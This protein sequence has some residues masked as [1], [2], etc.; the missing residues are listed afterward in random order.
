MYWICQI[1]YVVPLFY[2]NE[3]DAVLGDSLLSLIGLYNFSLEQYRTSELINV[4]LADWEN[5]FI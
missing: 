2:N 5:L 3:C 4:T 1:Q